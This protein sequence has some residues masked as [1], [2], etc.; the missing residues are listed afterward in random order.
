[1]FA[2]LL[3]AAAATAQTWQLKTFKDWIV[4]CDNG[5]LCQASA[6]AGDL[7]PGLVVTV[8]REPLGSSHPQLWLWPVDQD[9]ADI[10]VDGKRLHVH[11]S[12]NRDGAF[13]VAPEDVMGLL[14]SLRLA[15]EAHA[16][17]KNGKNVGPI[18][19]DGMT[20]A[21]LYIDDGQ[22]RL[23]TRGAF[24]RRDEKPDS[25]VPAPPGLPVRPSVRGSAK[26]PSTLSSTFIAK[27]RK[28]NDDADCWQGPGPVSYHR[29]DANHTFAWIT[30]LC[31]SGAY[32][33]I[34]A[35]YVIT[36]GGSG[37]QPVKFDDDAPGD[38]G[39]IHYNLYWNE[40]T[41]RL[42][43]GMKG[44]GHADCGG[45]QHYVW[46]GARFR[47]VGDEEMSECREVYDFISVWRARVVTH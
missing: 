33:F 7:K 29:L 9:P 40:K 10:S 13:M 31:E 14:D 21:L 24:V 37:P 26:P 15:K 17:D 8:K 47:L 2:G 11:L 16:T 12:K 6:M 20:A 25:S 22:H 44:R 45:R 34:S 5:R 32:N 3:M 23:G 46:D 39:Q 27:V 42:D 18:N 38:D 35:N 30:L 19:V 4:G 41:G 36:D 28:E 1:M 43:A